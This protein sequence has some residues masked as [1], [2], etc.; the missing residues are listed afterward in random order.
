VRIPV[1]QAAFKVAPL[2]DPAADLLVA[3]T[4]CVW[5]V[6]VREAL[7]RGWTNRASTLVRSAAERS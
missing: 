7:R 4:S 3:L 5:I 2:L 6:V 1:A